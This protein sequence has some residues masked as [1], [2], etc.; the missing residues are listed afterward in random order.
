MAGSGMTANQP[1]MNPSGFVPCPT[2]VSPSSDIMGGSGLTIAPQAQRP[3]CS[4]TRVMGYGETQT[5]RILR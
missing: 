4:Q 2:I 1:S 3:L 5:K